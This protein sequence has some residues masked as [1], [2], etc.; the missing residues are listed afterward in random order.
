[1]TV[2]SPLINAFGLSFHH[3]GLACRHPEAA[4]AFAA[5]LGYD[6]GEKIHDPVQNVNL[7]FCTH[8]QMPALEIVYPTGSV[9]P[10]DAILE[11]VGESLYHSCYRT[12]DLAA[13]LAAFKA[14]GQRIICVSPPKPAMLFGGRYVSFY[15]VKG[16]GLIEVL[17]S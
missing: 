15:R 9:G 11:K 7:I 13:S 2:E 5:G 14:A 16:I 17:E 3:V 4:L 12:A 10:I 1:L 8:A 6:A